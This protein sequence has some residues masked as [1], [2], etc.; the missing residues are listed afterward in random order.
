M[1][2]LCFF[3]FSFFFSEWSARRYV[4]R[5]H[6]P[7]PLFKYYLLQ[8]DVE[9]SLAL[10]I[11]Y[12]CLF[13]C[14][15]PTWCIEDSLVGFS[16]VVLHSAHGDVELPRSNPLF[17]FHIL[18]YSPWG[19]ILISPLFCAVHYRSLL[20]QSF[21]RLKPKNNNAARTVWMV[22]EHNVRRL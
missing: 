15:L 1:A 22:D 14:F 18:L 9:R 5:M 10:F 17:T 20:T 13:Y 2:L 6:P 7:P 8:G 12:T 3:V 21:A 4:L 19:T 16:I 11:A